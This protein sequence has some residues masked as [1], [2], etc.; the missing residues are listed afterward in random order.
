MTA[1]DAE[2]IVVEALRHAER[3]TDHQIAEIRGFDG[4]TE[5]LL[6]LA[7]GSVVAGFS[8]ATYLADRT[9]GADEVLALWRR[10]AVVSRSW[11]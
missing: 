11:P 4:R 3:V 9:A 2:D 6:T 1:P 8:V 5:Q 10:S 7:S